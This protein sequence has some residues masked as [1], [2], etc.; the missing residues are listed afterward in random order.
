MET[1]QNRS[2]LIHKLELRKNHSGME[3]S[4]RNFE[5]LPGIPSC[6]RTIVVWKRSPRN[7][8][9]IQ[10]NRCVRTIVVWKLT[11]RKHCCLDFILLRK[12]HS[13]METSQK[14]ARTDLSSWGCVRTIV[15]WKL[16]IL[17]SYAVSSQPCCVRTIVVWKL[18]I[19][20]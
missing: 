17:R 2:C 1:R 8:A 20:L 19:P 5:W 12:N 7:Q 10:I 9:G 15:V 11:S 3:T 6:V 14:T 13:G 18:L 4:H 16:E